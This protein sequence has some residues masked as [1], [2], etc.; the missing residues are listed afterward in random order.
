MGRITGIRC[1]VA[2]LSRLLPLLSLFAPGWA[3]AGIN[4]WTSTGPEGGW[5][6]AP[7]FHPTRSGV[8][9]VAAGRVYRSTDG[10]AHWVAVSANAAVSGSFVFDPNDPSR[11]LASGQPVLRSTDGGATFTDASPVPGSL[12]VSALAITADGGTVYAGSAGKVY[13]STDFG[14]TWQARS[15]NLPTT[16]DGVTGLVTSP[17]DNSTLYL[18][19]AT[20]GVFKSTDAGSTWNHLA[21][22]ADGVNALAI[23]PRNAAQLLAAGGNSAALWRSVDSGATWSSVAGSAYFQGMAY[24]PLVF[25][26]VMAYEYRARRLYVSTDGGSAWVPAAV[27]PATQGVSGAFSPTTSGM[28]AM[29]SSAGIFIST[30]AGH[31]L[32][33][34]NSG[35]IASD[36]RSLAVSRTSPYRVYGSFY[37]GPDGV[38]QRTPTTWQPTNAAQF[39]SLFPERNVVSALGVDPADSSIIYAGGFG[40]LARSLDGGSSWSLIWNGVFAYAVA[41]DPSD[42]RILYVAD[43]TSGVSRSADGGATWSLRNNGLPVVGVSVPI[44]NI[45]IDPNVPTR[46]YAF[47]QSTNAVYRSVDAGLNWARISGLQS[48]EFA[49][50]V[51]FDTLDANRAY[52]GAQSGAYRSLDGG[53]TWSVMP[54]PLGSLAVF[55]V[56]VDPVVPSNIMLVA[57]SGTPGV[58]RSVDRGATWERVPWDGGPGNFPTGPRIGVLDPDQPGNLLVSASRAGVREFQI[59]PDLSLSMSGVAGRMPPGSTPTLRISVQNKVDSQFASSEASVTVSLPAMF[60]PGPVSSTRGSCARA[61]QVI[62]C[63]IG[64]LKV[65][66][67]AQIDVPLV[68]SVGTGSI[69]ASVQGHEPDLSSPDNSAETVVSVQAYSDLRATFTAPAT[70]NHGSPASFDLNLTNLGPQGALNTRVVFNVPAALT[71][72]SGGACTVAGTTVTCLLGT[73]AANATA[74]VQ[75]APIATSVGQY[76]VS[77]TVDSSSFDPD[78]ANNAASSTV[79]VRPVTDLSATLTGPASLPVGQVGTGSATI[80]NTGPDPV[81]VVVVSLSSTNLNLDT[82]TA[83]GGSC[84]ISSGTANCSLGSL[85]AGA[86]RVVD[87]SFTSVAA[88]AAQLSASTNSEAQDPVAANN[89]A[90]LA[91]TATPSANLGVALAPTISSINRQSST[92]IAARVTNAGPTV[93]PAARLVIT[94]PAGLAASSANASTGA[95]TVAP[96]TVDCSLG[97]LNNGDVATVDVTATGALTG[98]AT[99]TGAVS[100]SAY[101]AVAANNT[102]TAVVTVRGLTDLAISLSALPSSLQPGQTATTTVTVSN[103]G[104]DDAGIV[105]A[106]LVTSNLDVQSAVPVAGTCSVSGASTD[107]SLGPL[108][109]G[110]SRTIAV[111]V[112][113][114]AT[115]AALLSATTSFEGGERAGTDNNTTISTTVASASNGGGSAGGG[116]S[117]GGGGAVGGW[118]L[119]ALALYLLHPARRRMRC[120]GMTWAGRG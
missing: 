86:S 36:V 57:A 74:L 65:G 33:A 39:Y 111:T 54:V 90:S 68:A 17:A 97:S 15:G 89:S 76:T 34:S 31:T 117:G 18:G 16:G 118:S 42:P 95:C 91:V 94:L 88:G 11:I 27:V 60:E 96:G 8:M 69:R 26:R 56:L 23:N 103:N 14:Q 40:G 30:D 112:M 4:Q 102:A 7:A 55:S 77:A 93:A 63:R 9:F 20:G 98:A 75:L 3:G 2:G 106:N 105:V 73:L 10:G 71:A 101:D 81:N 104:P 51:S 41:I 115:G 66:D 100:T 83:N 82:A 70:V 45:V 120:L 59:A 109:S 50:T 37:G 35:L 49:Y 72:A 28:F 119:L 80:T 64:A 32:Q 12:S 116:S 107:C 29:G 85:A 79:T 58:V 25:N 19:L 99:A 21:N 87:M 22:L 46:L 108:A 5:T 114:R 24:D 62:T 110:A 67:T 53:A 52:M 6:S 13:G 84:S 78:G 44:Y 113:T 61:S 1:D 38:Q 48:G 47:D 92:V 43:T